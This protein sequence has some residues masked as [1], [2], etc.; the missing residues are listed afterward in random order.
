MGTCK[1]KREN[2]IGRNLDS[3]LTRRALLGLGGRALSLVGLGGF[4]WLLGRNDN[5]LRPPGTLPEEEFLSL[6]IK[7]QKCQEVCPT[8]AITSVLLTESAAGAGTPRLSFR[9]GYCN[10]SMRCIEVCPTG[11]LQPIEKE[12]VELGVAEIDKDRCIAW[13]WVGCTRCYSKCPEEAIF[14]D[15]AQRPVVDVDKC[16][17]CGLCEYIC[18]SSSLRSYP[19]ARGKGIVVIPK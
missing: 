16:N 19:E 5:F 6:C 12:A 2:G 17:G 10:L 11:A 14:L 4:I 1:G 18:P 9:L 3:T 15:S 8:G 13:N 7:C